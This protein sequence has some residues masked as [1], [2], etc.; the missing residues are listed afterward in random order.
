MIGFLMNAIFPARAGE[1]ARAAVLA[2]RET[3]PFSSVLGSV[4][5]ERIFD[6]VILLASFVFVLSLLGATLPDEPVTFGNVTVTP[7]A[8]D[9]AVTGSII[10]V[11][12][13]LAGVLFVLLPRT[14]R[15]AL[16]LNR[17]VFPEKISHVINDQ[18]EKLAKGFDSLRSATQIAL[19]VFW[20]LVV[21][22]TV[23][24]SGWEAAWGFDE[25]R[26]MT[27]LQSWAITVFVCIF[28][29]VPASP[30]YWGLYEV[31]VIVACGT[32]GLTQDKS[33]ALSYGLVMHFW[34]IATTIGVGLI[35]L[36]REGVS[37]A[38]LKEAKEKEAA[39][40]DEV[41]GERGQV[42]GVR[43]QVSGDR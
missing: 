5:L 29:L 11:A 28:I 4:L 21:W 19:I 20:T 10:M 41:R 32:L 38:Q 31:G 6:G 33:V 14:R 2:R 17:K 18:I 30:G 1:F 23:A 24:L 35:F 9:N 25:L 16:A 8:I 27:F 15:I 36:W 13:V 3:I 26:G 42:T 37:L 34:Q 12:V 22:A 39:N 40:S 43:G 7:Q